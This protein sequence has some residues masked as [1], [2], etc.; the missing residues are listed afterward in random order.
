[1][2]QYIL[3]MLWSGMIVND[4][5]LIITW[6]SHDS[7]LISQDKHA[8]HEAVTSIQRNGVGLKGYYLTVAQYVYLINRNYTN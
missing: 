3:K 2:H 5:H 8:I 6:I 7:G 4:N 1:M